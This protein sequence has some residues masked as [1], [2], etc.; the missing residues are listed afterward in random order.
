MPCIWTASNF[1]QMDR[2]EGEAVSDRELSEEQGE[3][4]R[5]SAMDSSDEE[6]EEETEADKQFIVDDVVEAEIVRKRKHSTK[7][8]EDEFSDDEM[9]LIQENHGVVK[10]L[11]QKHDLS[12]L[13]DQEDEQDDL[14]HFI[15]RDDDDGDN[16]SVNDEVTRNIGSGYGIDDETWIDVQELFGDGTDYQYAMYS[17]NQYAE[18]HDQDV[19]FKKKQVTLK[20]VYEPSEITSRMLT[21]QDEEVRLKDVPERMQ[22]SRMPSDLEISREATY[23]ARLLMRDSPQVAENDMIV[24]VT[25]VLRFLK[26][27]MF[28][29][30]FLAQHRKGYFSGVLTRAHLWKIVDLDEKFGMCQVK[31]DNLQS[32]IE[33]VKTLTDL[34]N[35]PIPALIEQVM[36]IDDAADISHYMH[37]EHSRELETVKRKEVLKTRFK[38]QSWKQI[39]DDALENNI[40]GFVDRLHVNIGEYVRS[41]TRQVQEFVPRDDPQPP[42]ILAEQ[43]VS[44]RF[45]TV[46]KV[47]EA[48]HIVLSHKIAAHPLFRSFL[49]RVYY[50]DAVVTV[51][52]TEKGK[53]EI[54]PHHPF[55]VPY[56]LI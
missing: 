31:K 10:K 38:K 2:E 26:R 4:L 51:Y 41:V 5:G 53:K 18:E 6:E 56:L 55:Y 34:S 25:S 49:R 29:V 13:F 43:F 39:F 30:P 42:L 33:Q 8:I 11:R 22:A 37:T 12:D 16:V 46:E 24:S 54:T 3:S 45:P 15:I 23:V 14:D 7:A 27:D 36:T 21:E 50:T 35:S 17:S 48:A 52:V 20:D 47:I 19:E 9:D 28:E 1:F 40:L 44:A 32:L